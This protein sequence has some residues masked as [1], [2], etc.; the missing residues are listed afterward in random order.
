MPLFLCVRACVCVR[1]R[2]F[3]C[4]SY[5]QREKRHRYTHSSQR[6][7]AW[8]LLRAGIHTHTHTHT[9]SHTGTGR[10]DSQNKTEASPR[11][12]R[13]RQSQKQR[14]MGH[15][16][17]LPTFG[18][19]HTNAPTNCPFH[20]HTNEEHFA[21]T[22]EPPKDAVQQQL[23]QKHEYHGAASHQ[24]QLYKREYVQYG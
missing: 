20:T 17:T 11:T 10:C 12:Y 13:H 19:P 7:I 16:C 9:H 5:T 24:P 6:C 2:A 23:V 18:M 14:Q 21:V 8:F 1:A 3:E 15:A 22:S 4:G